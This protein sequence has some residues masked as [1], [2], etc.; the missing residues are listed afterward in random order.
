MFLRATGR[1][2]DAIEAKALLE[3]LNAQLAFFAT[4][5]DDAKLVASVGKHPTKSNLKRADVAAWT[6]VAQ[7]ILNSDACVWKR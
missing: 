1:E 5:Q 2:P 4:R 7:A 6:M 3:L